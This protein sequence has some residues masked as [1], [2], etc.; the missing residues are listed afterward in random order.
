MDCV[1]L[2]NE[3]IFKETNKL[4]ETYNGINVLFRNK[5]ADKKFFN[6]LYIG[7]EIGIFNIDNFHN[8]FSDIMDFGLQPNETIIKTFYNDVTVI[9]KKNRLVYFDK[10]NYYLGHVAYDVINKRGK[11]LRNIFRKEV[12]FNESEK[13]NLIKKYLDS[14]RRFIY[15]SPY[16]SQCNKNQLIEFICQIEDFYKIQ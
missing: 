6:K 1:V 15:S 16:Y 13:N 11:I 3:V 8:V 5:E 14:A 4:F 7:Q 10:Q 12:A 9:S 2:N